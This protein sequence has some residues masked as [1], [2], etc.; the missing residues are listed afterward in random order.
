MALLAR[1]HP[2][3]VHGG[4]GYA[5]WFFAN[6]EFD[7]CLP[8]SARGRPGTRFC[9]T[10][11]CARF[12]SLKPGGPCHEIQVRNSTVQ[13][14]TS[15]SDHEAQRRLPL[16]L[17]PPPPPQRAL[18]PGTGCVSGR[19]CRASPITLTLLLDAAAA[20]QWEASNEAML[21]QVRSGRRSHC[22]LL[23]RNMVPVNQAPV[24]I[25]HCAFGYLVYGGR[26]CKSAMQHH[27]CAMC[28]TRAGI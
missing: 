16:L 17:L 28:C 7:S 4:G 26:H 20:H 8:F 1:L 23:R 25:W 9:D 18:L 15:I 12:R 11:H 6:M 13:T 21:L 22:E 27:G 24:A 10:S 2:K 14:S 3:F 19:C 5:A